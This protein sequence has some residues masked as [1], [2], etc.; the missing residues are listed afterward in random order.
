VVAGTNSIAALLKASL[1]DVQE[2]VGVTQF[3]SEHEWVHIFGGLIFQGGVVS[4]SAESDITVTFNTAFPKQVLGVFITPAV[5]SVTPTRENFI[6]HSDGS[7]VQF[8][9]FAIGI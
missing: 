9:W 6:V 2:S 7:D 1:E 4:R 3:Q 5:F 8:Y